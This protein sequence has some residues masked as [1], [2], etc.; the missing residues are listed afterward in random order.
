MVGLA[1]LD[2]PH[3]LHTPPPAPRMPTLKT[4]TLGCKVNQYETEYVR[5]GLVQVGYRDA[6]DDE[7]P[8]LCLVNTCSVTAE[9]EAKCRKIIRRLAQQHPGMGIIVM[10]CYA[11]R[12]PAEVAA[13]PGI[14]E[15]VTDKR[16]LPDLLARYGVTD[17]PEGIS[18]F[19]SRRRAY[20]KVQDGCRLHCAFC[21][22]P[23]VRPVL[24]S[25]RVADVL[26]EIRRLTEN[27]HREIVLT[28]IHLGHYGLDRPALPRGTPRVRL[29]GLLAKIVELPGQ[30]RV[31]LS[32]LEAIE[33]RGELIAV[34][35]DNP[36]RVCPHLHL[37][38]QSGSDA[39]LARMRRRWQSSRFVERC[40][41][42]RAALGNPALT[43]DVI[44]GFPGETEDDFQA[45]CRVCEVIGFAKI[46][47]FRF[48]PRQGT[49]AADMPDQV[50]DR[51]KQQRAMRLE[52]LGQRLR[53]QYLRSLRGCLLQVLVQS[54]AAGKP[55][56]MY[57][58]SGQYVPVEL[59]GD[60]RLVNQL[61]E[62]E[63][64]GEG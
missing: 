62:V 8:Q 60:E 32:S 26:D 49:P 22:I 9:G 31:R 1:A 35:R 15:V 61:V 44:V 23:Q 3:K 57:G 7:S 2:P 47:I 55:G 20:V 42:A 24:G 56:R 16:L 39:V 30:F 36:Q 48:S 50:Q 21:I 45:T 41:E 51:V 11:T 54:P 59:P 13:L 6:R 34:M 14:L 53:Q 25:R 28:G 4:V 58:I 17:V 10:G 18:T 27:G 52:E 43:T 40:L 63:Y 64:K 37:S 29:A 46:H 5:Q 38:M 19:R 33:A 12:A